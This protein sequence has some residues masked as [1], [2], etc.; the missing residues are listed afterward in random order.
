MA[1]QYATD[2]K[3]TPEQRREKRIAFD[4]QYC[5]HYDPNGVSMIGGKPPTGVCKAGVNYLDQF[6]R[7]DPDDPRSYIE[8]KYYEKASIYARMCC[9][10]GNERT[11]EEQ[12]A[13]CPKWVQ[14]TRE[15][16]EK[17]ADDLDEALRRMTVAGPVVAAWRK[18]LPIGKQEVIDCPV[19]CGGRLHLSQSSYNGHV[20][21]QCTTAGCLNWME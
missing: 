4:R 8:G 19:G 1:K 10:S 13:S 18:K 11:H 7:A 14:R 20:H 21:G 3:M 2:S 5:Q 6:G 16:G 17:R 9:T 15:Q 12:I